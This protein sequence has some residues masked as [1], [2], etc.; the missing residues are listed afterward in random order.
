MNLY[1]FQEFWTDAL[2]K[3][4][5]KEYFE[6]FYDGQIYDCVTFGHTIYMSGKDINANKRFIRDSKGRFISERKLKCPKCGKCV[7]KDGHDP[8]I[9]NL[10]GVENACCGHGIKEGYIAFKNGPVI[11]GNFKVEK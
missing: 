9:A 8:C 3:K 1:T 4:N 2:K 7:T 11:R 5:Q 6:D 10:P